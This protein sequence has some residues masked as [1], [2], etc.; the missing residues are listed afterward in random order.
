[1]PGGFG[2]PSSYR[3]AEICC[4]TPRIKTHASTT[5]RFWIY[6]G[7]GWVPLGGAD[8]PLREAPPPSLPGAPPPRPLRPGQV[9]GVRRG[10]HGVFLEKTARVA[11][12]LAGWRRARQGGYATRRQ[13]SGPRERE[14]QWVGRSRLR[15]RE[16]IPPAAL[17]RG[18]LSVL[19]LRLL[20]PGVSVRPSVCL[21]VARAVASGGALLPLLSPRSVR[22]CGGS[23][24][25]VLW[26]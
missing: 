10:W 19:S 15:V 7:R 20:P 12:G 3:S 1:M 22:G 5:V 14:A 4:F 2:F 11:G 17:F 8:P 23:T 6:I 16:L 13:A 24:G 25:W 26:H 18:P 9:A 21:S